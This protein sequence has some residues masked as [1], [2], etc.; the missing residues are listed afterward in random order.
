M[1][2]TSQQQPFGHYYM[3]FLDLVGRQNIR[4]FNM[5][6]YLH[7]AKWIAFNA[8]YHFFSLDKAAD[9]LYG[10]AG[11][12][13]ALRSS[14]NAAAGGVVGQEI[15]ILINFHLTT[16]SDIIL[17]YSRMQA[18]EFIRNTAPNANAARDSELFYAMYNFRW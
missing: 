18:G 6:L 2:G 8:Q 4:D 3:G 11:N 7:P 12:P 5:H 17:G 10:V 15:D 1:P 16:Q 9:A 14:P 13:N